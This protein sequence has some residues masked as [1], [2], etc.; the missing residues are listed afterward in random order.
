MILALGF[1]DRKIVDAGEP[2]AHKTMGRSPSEPDGD[3]AN[4]GS[5]PCRGATGPCVSARRFKQARNALRARIRQALPATPGWAA[6]FAHPTTHPEIV[7]MKF[8][9]GFEFRH[10]AAA[11]A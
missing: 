4:L 2:R 5:N 6:G 3:R 7:P 10:L 11:I 1:F 9:H 8:N